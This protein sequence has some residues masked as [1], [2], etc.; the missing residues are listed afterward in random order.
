[1]RSLVLLT[2][3]T[4]LLALYVLQGKAIG[5]PQ[6]VPAISEAH[7]DTYTA[8]LLQQEGVGYK[9]DQTPTWTFAVTNK[10][11]HN[12]AV[13]QMQNETDEIEELALVNDVLVVLGSNRKRSQTDCA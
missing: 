6:G 12:E 7:N 9:T 2:I 13:R 11:T 4:A 5:A 8:R 10:E 1:M 3:A